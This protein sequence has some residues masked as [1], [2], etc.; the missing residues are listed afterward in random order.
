MNECLRNG[1]NI[2]DI[3]IVSEENRQ[4]TDSG[5]M[6]IEHNGENWNFLYDFFY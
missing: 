3:I 2:E 1:H 4:P 5:R 6:N